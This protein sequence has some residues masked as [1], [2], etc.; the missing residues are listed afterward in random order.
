[1]S[2]G[3]LVTS[4]GWKLHT[5]SQ[6]GYQFHWAKLSHGLHSPTPHPKTEVYGNKSTA[7]M[8]SLNRIGSDFTTFNPRANACPCKLTLILDEMFVRNLRWRARSG[9]VPR[10]LRRTQ[11][12][13]D[14][15]RR[16]G[17]HSEADFCSLGRYAHSATR[18][19]QNFAS[20]GRFFQP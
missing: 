8:P 6:S 13:G 11:G 10:G 14:R 7:K 20:M 9:D 19:G 16:Y 1:V 5:F 15:R 2:R 4:F 12:L 18:I 17:L 3:R